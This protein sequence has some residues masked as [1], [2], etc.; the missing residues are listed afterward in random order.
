MNLNSINKNVVGEQLKTISQASASKALEDVAGKHYKMG[1][2]FLVEKNYALSYYSYFMSLKEYAKIIVSK[3]IKVS[4]SYDEALEYLSKNKQF[5][6]NKTVLSQVSEIALSV[7]NRKKLERKDC[8][9]IKEFIM[10]MR[11]QFS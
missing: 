6:L 11:K 8:V 3:K 5:G 1:N 2:G 4:V 10:K 7:L 9:F